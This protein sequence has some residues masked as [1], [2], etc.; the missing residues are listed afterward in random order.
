MLG[1]EATEEQ[2]QEMARKL[3]E[4]GYDVEYTSDAGAVNGEDD[5]DPIPEDVWER[6]V[7][8]IGNC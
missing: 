5:E 6:E 1:S 2:T 7:M 3:R 8:A 4:L